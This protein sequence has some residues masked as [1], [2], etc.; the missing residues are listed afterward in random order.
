M[1]SST[2]II[3]FFA[4]LLAG[5]AQDSSLTAQ[6][7]VDIALQ[8][9]LSIQIAKSDLD[10]SR[11]N[12][13]W[14]NS[15]RWPIVTAGFGNN[16]SLVNLDQKLSNGTE[17]VRN[18]TTQN[19]TNANITAT[20]RIYNGM[21]VRATKSR[22]EELEKI[23]SINLRQQVSSV[24][25]DVLLTYYNIIRNKQQLVA[26]SAIIDL[27]K[28][29][30]KIAETRFNVGS[31]A[32][33]D[34]L[35]AQTDLHEQEIA[36]LDI[37]RQ[38]EQSKA[39]LNNL[40]KRYPSTPLDTKDSSFHVQM[41]KLDDFINKLDSQNYDLLRAQRDREVLAQERRIINSNRLPVISLN[42]VNSFNRTMA[43]AGLFLTNQTYG[44]NLGVSVGVPIYN[45]NITK[46]QLKVNEA[47]QKQQVLQTDLLRSQLQRDMFI[48]YSEY[49]DALKTLEKE[50]L[51]VK[52]AEEN[53]FIATERFKK[54]QSNSIELRQAQLSL[55]DAQDR[56]INA[57]FRAKVAETTIEFLS[58]EVGVH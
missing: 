58:G 31:A 39:T 6:E 23:G 43:S 20:W 12:N 27:S 37:I 56:L 14:G 3:I 1:K 46:T 35:Q 40:L 32:K 17:I 45:S 53:N 48:A 13:N 4:C 47:Q 49:Q 18:G 16:E 11:I 9:N 5:Q 22:F 51:N 38:L 52:A 57:E 10:I 41:I 55:I 30:L 15:G 36:I 25:Y 19:T 26:L 44:P 54:L 28:E 8:N 7:A 33:T 2:L 34:M 24:T 50:K 21:R 42:N 29:R